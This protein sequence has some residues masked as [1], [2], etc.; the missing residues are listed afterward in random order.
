M[1]DLDEGVYLDESRSGLLGPFTLHE[2][3][4]IQILRFASG[5]KSQDF[6]ECG[7]KT[8]TNNRD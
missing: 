7:R 3:S 2:I 8:V 5:S 4:G 6:Y 1:K